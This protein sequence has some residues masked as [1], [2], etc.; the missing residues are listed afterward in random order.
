MLPQTWLAMIPLLADAAKPTWL[1]TSRKIRYFLQHSNAPLRDPQR[2]LS[3]T[4]GLESL[5]VMGMALLVA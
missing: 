4:E 2:D 3:L 1:S 5:D